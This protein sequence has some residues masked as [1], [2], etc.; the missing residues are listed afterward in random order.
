MQPRRA[1]GRRRA[2]P[3]PSRISSPRIAASSS[4]RTELP[5]P[6][7]SARRGQRPAEHGGRPPKPHR[8]RKIRRPNAARRQAETPAAAS[9]SGCRR[10]L[11]RYPRARRGRRPKR[12]C[13]TKPIASSRSS[14][15]SFPPRSASGN[16]KPSGCARRSGAGAGHAARSSAAG[17]RFE[18]ARIVA[19]R[20]AAPHRHHAQRDRKVHQGPRGR[21]RARQ[22][23]RGRARRA[24]SRPRNEG[25]DGAARSRTASTSSTT[26]RRASLRRSGNRRPP[27]DRARP[28]GPDA[29]QLAER[30]VH[31]PR[32]DE[33]RARRPQGGRQSGAAQRRRR[34]QL[35]QRRRRHPMAFD[36]KRWN[37]FVKN[38]KGSKDRIERRTERELEIEQQAEDARACSSTRTRRSAK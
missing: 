31:P 32:D 17:E 30:Q 7:G 5:L 23:E 33:P 3:S 14:P 22:A 15:A 6:T 35:R 11:T 38:R 25:Q 12:R 24:R 9:A 37:D 20:A 18:A 28:G 13:S 8:A 16:P 36:Q 10:R 4:R 34:V 27:A 2:F 26:P 21:D 29:Q 1:S 19:T